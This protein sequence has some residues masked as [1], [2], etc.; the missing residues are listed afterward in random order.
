MA[1]VSR[2]TVLV[3]DSAVTSA[4]TLGVQAAPGAAIGAARGPGTIAQEDAVTARQDEDAATGRAIT[5]ADIARW[6]APGTNAP[7]SVQFSPDGA[8][9]TYL[10]SADNSL[11]QELWAYDLA[12]GR[13]WVL[14]DAPGLD[15]PSKA[16]FTRIEEVRRERTR[17]NTYGVTSYAWGD[18]GKILMAR[19]QGEVL[20]R[21]GLEGTWRALPGS[22][23]WIDP[24]LSPDETRIAFAL[25]GELRVFD[26]DA[27]AAS[28]RQLTFDASPPDAYG[29]R[30]VTNGIAE[31]DAQEEL[32]RMSGFWWSP[33][34]NRLL[35]EQADNAEVPPY[36]I[37]HAGTATVE[38]ESLRYPFAGRPLTPAPPGQR[39]CHRRRRDLVAIR[40]R[41]RRLPGSR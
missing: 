20:V 15:H 28:P 27:A 8:T 1:Q 40:R 2:R 4:L 5:F 22:H 3:T 39:A 23:V 21:S 6:P 13:E 29:D 36:L 33:D 26:L 41:S 38:V 18:I 25:D 12:T 30:A 14:L 10:Y 35:F 37:T 32:G 24:R 19:R 34:G 17:Q 31:Y 11:V 16:D 7:S 9:L